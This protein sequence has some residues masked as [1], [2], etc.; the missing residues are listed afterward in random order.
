MSLVLSDAA[1]RGSVFTGFENRLVAALVYDEQDGYPDAS[2]RDLVDRCRVR[3]IRLAGV[4][5]QQSG[6]A[7]HRCDVLLENLSTGALISIFAS[8]GRAARGCKLDQSAMIQTIA[9]IEQA[10]NQ[11]P[12]LLVLNKFGKVEAEG[13]GMR[14]LIAQAVCSGTPV[15]IA[16]PVR[17]LAKWREFAADF[18]VELRGTDDIAGWLARCDEAIFGQ[19]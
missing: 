15:V 10:L 11:S 16:V 5:Q 17:N 19:S 14:G 4:V 3:N 7:N 9:E 1:I 12:Q 2:L 18:S 13:A 8:R 6:E